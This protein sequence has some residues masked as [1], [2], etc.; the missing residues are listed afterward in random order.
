MQICKHNEIVLH[1]LYIVDAA[2]RTGEDHFHDVDDAFGDLS[3]G[4]GGE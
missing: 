2:Y 3:K 1:S 4:A